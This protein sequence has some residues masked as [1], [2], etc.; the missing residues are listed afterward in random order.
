MDEVISKTYLEDIDI[1]GKDT[2][3][4]W[5]KFDNANILITGASGLIGN[6]LVDILMSRENINYHVY[7]SGR[8]ESR[9]RKLY[10][11]YL[12][13]PFFHIIVFDVTSELNSNIEFHYIF[14][15]ASGANPIEYSTNPIGVIKGNIWGCENL[16][17]YG[18]THNMR[19]FLYVSSGDVY[20][21]GDGRIF[22]EEYSGYVNPL[23][24]RSCYAA[25]KRTSESLCVSYYY[26]H[27]IDVVIARPCHTFGPHISDSAMRVFAQFMRNVE[28]NEEI[29]LK[30]RGE[31]FRSWCYV[32]DCAK[33]LLYIMLK[34]EVA[35]A[36]NIADSK[37]MLTIRELAEMFASYNNRN[38]RFDIPSEQESKGY[39]PATKSILD[40]SKL[41]KLG[42]STVGNIQS[43]IYKSII[44]YT[45]CR[46][47][48]I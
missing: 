40:N 5:A 36:Y 11:K 3:L 34:G 17:T 43:N 6:C 9:L 39:N 37:S 24:V 45:N 44:E 2:N 33:G 12:G 18:K 47:H 7:A 13:S 42:W 30:S 23:L 8:N 38:V 14:H 29:V 26:Q 21:E 4:P 31:Q 46:R 15:A 27:N 32:V 28:N 48:K 35:Q 22:T 16:L 25:S 10:E 1:A 41:Q 20:G 19:R